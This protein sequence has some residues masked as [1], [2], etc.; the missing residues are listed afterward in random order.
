M[1]SRRKRSGGDHSPD[2]VR[3]T[4]GRVMLAMFSMLGPNGVDGKRVLDLYAGTGRLG[5]ESLKRGA[6][7]VELIEA[8]ARRCSAIQAA[9]EQYGFTDLC[10]VRRG[11]VE[12]IL[13]GLDGVYDI[14]F[15]DPPYAMDPFQ[16]VLDA[17]GGRSLLSSEATVFAEH[18]KRT[19]L[20][21]QYAGLVK[22]DS[23]LYGDT[24]VTTFRPVENL[25]Q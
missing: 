16:D 6:A 3:P 13:R 9:V 1:P 5:L 4:S 18:G 12:R 11:R 19:G 24:A 25:E 7:F 8:D 17:L 22:S 21:G 15:I 20:D 23:R 14:V 2:R 10:N